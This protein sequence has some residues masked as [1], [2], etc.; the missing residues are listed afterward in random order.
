MSHLDV[1][2]KDRP[3]DDK[4]KKN[5]HLG[6]AVI[7]PDGTYPEEDGYRRVSEQDRIATI[8]KAAAHALKITN[9]S[10]WVAK[11]GDRVLDPARTFAE[12]KLCCV[13]DIEYHKHEGG[14][15]A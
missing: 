8:L 14:G 13:V 6:V 2:E 4:D 10:D 9:T 1:L 3:S 12:E 11:V 7:T 5:N 15:G